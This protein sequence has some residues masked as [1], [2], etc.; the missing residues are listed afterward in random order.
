MHAARMQSSGGIQFKTRYFV[1][2]FHGWGTRD[3]ND[4]GTAGAEGRRG[5]GE[6]VEKGATSGQVYRGMEAGAEGRSD[7]QARAVARGHQQIEA[8]NDRYLSRLRETGRPGLLRRLDDHNQA[9]RQAIRDAF[10]QHT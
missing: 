4:Y 10:Q 1:A 6:V 5:A 2:G 8:L 7:V 3:P 9:I